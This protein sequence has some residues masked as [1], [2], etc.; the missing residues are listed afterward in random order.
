MTVEEIFSKITEHMIEGLMYHDAFAN[1]FEFFG[2]EGFAREQ[3][4]HHIEETKNYRSLYR[5]YSSRF[6]KLIKIGEVGKPQIIP[7][8]W[9][10]YNTSA[11]D[12][13]TKRQGLKDIL[14]KWVEWE[15]STKKLYQDMRFELQNLGEGAAALR[16]D[17]CIKDVDK[18]LVGAERRLLKFE[19]IN[20]DIQIIVEQSELLLE[21]YK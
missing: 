12:T 16:L 14:T 10:K 6:H 13:N 1:M 11:V 19:T 18:E 4:Y 3:D 17:K 5:Y 21:K 15:K 2:F 20:Y 8:S 7:E 9:Y